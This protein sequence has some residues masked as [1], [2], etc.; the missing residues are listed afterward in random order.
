M[1]IKLT[2]VHS[3]L[4][5][6]TGREYSLREIHINPEHVIMIRE[7]AHTRRLNEER[8]IHG[9]L[10]IGHMFSKITINRGATPADI[11]VIGSPQI[12]ENKMNQVSR[13][14]LKG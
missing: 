1:L 12:I 7:E 9:D 5:I 2:E 10:E 13:T 11:I 6:T 3:N 8:L 4:A 14:L